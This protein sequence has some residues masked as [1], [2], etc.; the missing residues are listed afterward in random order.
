MSVAVI[1]SRR[2]LAGRSVAVLS[3]CRPVRSGMSLRIPIYIYGVPQ[4]LVV[5][6]VRPSADAAHYSGQRGQLYCAAQGQV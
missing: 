6:S 3:L 4:A 5:S 1:F 2:S